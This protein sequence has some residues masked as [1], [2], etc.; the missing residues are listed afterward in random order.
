MA[1]TDL[2]QTI[3]PL[4]HPYTGY[5]ERQK[6]LLLFFNNLSEILPINKKDYAA[7]FAGDGRKIYK[8]G[9][10]FS[11]DRRNIESWATYPSLT[12]R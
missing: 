10:N 12:A 6:R 2:N 3:K 9:I 11:A 8:V 5:L 7:A 1:S 4:H